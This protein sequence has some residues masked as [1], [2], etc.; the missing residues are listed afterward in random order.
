[1]KQYMPIKPI[2][3]GFKTWAIADGLNGS[4]CDLVLSVGATGGNACL[5][6]GEKV[7]LK[8]IQ[9]LFGRNHQV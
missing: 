7:V 8:L 3:Q 6:L 9:P 1:M 2:K 4:I 5:E